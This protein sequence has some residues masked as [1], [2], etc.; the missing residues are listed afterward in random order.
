MLILSYFFLV[1]A[2]YD[3]NHKIE[4]HNSDNTEKESDTIDNATKPK[5]VR[6]L[7]LL[8]CSSDDESDLEDFNTR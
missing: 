2:S 4:P 3:D 6:E 5:N 7:L 1:T 8:D